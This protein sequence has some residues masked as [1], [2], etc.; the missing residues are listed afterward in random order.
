MVLLGITTAALALAVV[1][2]ITF[3]EVQSSSSSLYFAK[4]IRI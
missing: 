3:G 1:G 2:L 4:K